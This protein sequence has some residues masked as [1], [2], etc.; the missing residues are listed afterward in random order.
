MNANLR[1]PLKITAGPAAG[2]DWALTALELHPVAHTLLDAQGHIRWQNAAARRLVGASAD[3]AIGRPLEQVSSCYAGEVARNPLAVGP[4]HTRLRPDGRVGHFAAQLTTIDADQYLLVELDVT[5]ILRGSEGEL[6]RQHRIRDIIEG[7]PDNIL[8]VDAFAVILDHSP[9][10]LDLLGYAPD[11]LIGRKIFELVHPDDLPELRQRVE[12]GGHVHHPRRFMDVMARLRHVDGSWR[13]VAAA[14]VNSLTVPN[15]EAVM[16]YLRD[17]T[18]QVELSNRLKQRERRFAALMQNSDDMI[19]LVT[20]DGHLAFESASV[21]RILGYP[22]SHFTGIGLVKRIHRS[23]RGRVLRLLRDVLTQQ[24][25]ARSVECMIQSQ[26]GRFHWIEALCVD[27]LADPDVEGILIT[28]RDI[29]AR[30]TAE[31]ERDTALKS[32]GIALWE[33]DFGKR[34]TRWIGDGLPDLYNTRNGFCNGDDFNAS[35]HPDDVDRVNERFALVASGKADEVQVEFRTRDAHGRWRWMIE[36]GRR[37]GFNP[38]TGA[39]RLAGVSIDITEQRLTEM[40][41]ATAR[42]QLQYAMGSAGF[43][44]YEWDVVADTASGL[45]DWCLSH[46]LPAE[47]P[48]GHD[49]RWTSYLHPDDAPETNRRFLAHLR[50]E[51]AYADL[52]YRIRVTGGQYLWMMDRCQVVQRDSTGKP[53]R[54][55]GLLI[56]IEDRKRVEHAL[57]DSEARL[58]TAIWGGSFGLWEMQV[59]TQKARWF[60]DWCE[61]EDLNPCDDGEHVATWDANIHPDDLAPAAH[62][63]SRM[64]NN[65]CD[66]FESEYRVRTRSGGWKWIF[67]RSRAIERDASGQPTVV[68]GICFNIDNR[69][70]AEQALLK[71]EA[72]YRN[73]ANLTRG[74]VCEYEIGN[75]KLLIT[76]ASQGFAEVFGA[77][78]DPATFARGWYLKYFEPDSIVAVRRS[79][80]ELTQGHRVE[81]EVIIRRLDGQR[82]W[83]RIIA[84]PIADAAGRFSTAIG[85][86][87]DITEQRQKEQ[88]LRL[89][90]RVLET[91]RE[92]VVLLDAKNTVKLSNP[93]FD[94][95]CGAN[96][97]SL[98]G[99]RIESFLLISPAALNNESGVLECDARRLDGSLFAA[100]AAITPMLVDG[101]PHRLLV[102]NDVSDRKLL[103]REILEVSSHEQQRIG[104]D[105]HDGLGQELTGVALMLRAL[106]AR[107]DRDYPQ[108]KQEI[109]DIVRLV[110]H[111]IDSTRALAR[112]LSPVS[113]E[114]GGLVPALETLVLR[115]RSA[116]GISILLRR[117]PR[118]P[119]RLDADAATHLYRI[120]Q[121][122]LTNAV[123]HGRATRVSI[124]VVSEN[125]YVEISVRD[126]GRGF[127]QVSG[128]PMGIGLKTMNYR[129]QM[130]RGTLSIK[131]VAGGGTAVRCRCPQRRRPTTAVVAS[132]TPKNRLQITRILPGS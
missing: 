51:T 96:L 72:L 24:G 112:G 130:L 12:G 54:V 64:T 45:N 113:I 85:V 124:T 65:E 34:I 73:V 42:Q 98:L 7:S 108:I 94:R 35:L 4:S 58:S 74:F 1:P 55:L 104:N 120:V 17:A 60:S 87:H 10:I 122:A 32:G 68:A 31:L 3:D 97:S 88:L 75:E 29:S 129:T 82:I 15:F 116:F 59:S 119:L 33:Y 77:P 19:L 100:A 67:E 89:Q 125:D 83:L 41:L 13:W 101:E 132:Q 92:G 43:A 47:G 53:L 8:A 69:K 126:N 111:S 76:W 11:G 110:N 23:H 91:I 71:S 78:F 80:E 103:E 21:H 50:G 2:A 6:K 123:R 109:D 99:E 106:S 84:Q 61:R 38:E 14:I 44:C 90:A 115:A 52:E 9:S 121:E 46:G 37:A 62:A 5:D 66:F 25:N 128:S 117:L 63:F 114:R 26:D 131:P 28:A 56:N 30:K 16:V 18:Q 22:K 36:R 93:A 81:I 39:P 105:L 79:V 107:V 40:Q 102:I 57:R 48:S 127:T 86:A 95:M 27:L 70:R 49:A 118:R 20:A